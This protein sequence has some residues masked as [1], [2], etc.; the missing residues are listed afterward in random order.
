LEL[1]SAYQVDFLFYNPGSDYYPLL[2]QMSKFEIENRK[3]PKP[4]LCLTEHLA[5]SMAH[6]YSMTNGK[7][8]TVMVHVGLGTMEIGG[9]LHNI[10]RGREPVLIVAGRSPYTFEGELPGGRDRPYHWDQDIFDQ[11]GIARQFSKWT[12]ELKTNSNMP[13]VLGRALQVAN[14]E[15]KGPSYLVLPRELLAEKQAQVKVPRTEVYL[16]PEPPQASEESLVRIA[17]ILEEAHTPIILTEFLGRNPKAVPELVELAEILGAP[18]IESQRKRMNFPSSNPLYLRGFPKEWIEN[19]DVILLIDADVPWAPAIHRIRPDA[20]I[21]QIDVDP[22]KSGMPLWGF[23]VHISISA[24]SQ[25][26]LHGLIKI[27]KI[28]AKNGRLNKSDERTG[29]IIDASQSIRNSL[30]KAAESG[31]DKTPM[32]ISSV[33]SILNDHKSFDTIVMSEGVSNEMV[34]ASY[35]ETDEPGTYYSLGG[36]SLGDGLG[37]ALGLKLANPGNDVLC[38][39]GDGGF[40]YSNP[41]SVFWVSRRYQLPILTVIIDNGGYNAMKG[42]VDR[43]YPEGISKLNDHYSGVR[44]DPHPD[45]VEAAKACGATGWKVKNTAE[46]EEAILSALNTIR[47]DKKSA[48]IDAVVDQV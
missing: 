25:L 17:S 5:L 40:V 4:I 41:T 33:I 43:G 34:V 8:Q 48:V 29:K 28:N 1:L 36:S 37:N 44:I 32:K 15:P 39:V 27:L 13:Y 2:E 7:A 12:Y 47:K 35:I 11:L 38:I 6:G 9:A 10:C 42:A 30:K 31:K 23:P 21:I 19:A 3:N 22:L 14:S 16:P 46:L 20:K 24:S 18:V 26:A 45:Y